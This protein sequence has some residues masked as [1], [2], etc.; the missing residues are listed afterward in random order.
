[1]I[2]FTSDLH[3][4]HD[5][6]F[7]YEPRGFK[8]VY[9]MNDAILK[10]WNSVVQPEDDVYVLGDLML[11][12]NETALKILHQLKGNIHIILGNHD[13]DARIELYNQS[14]NVV[15]VCYATVIKY[16]KYRFYLSHY[17]TMTANLEKERL[18]QCMINL[19]GHTH[20]KTNFYNDIPF[21]YHVGCDSHNCTPVTIEQIIED[22]KAKVIECKEML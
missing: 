13:T 2:Y 16:W 1:M 3:L 18:S 12:D 8:N 15:E 17:P 20:Q 4:C 21:M 6:G 22:C 10:N 7:L 9:D 5:R 19:Y 11:N 14:Y